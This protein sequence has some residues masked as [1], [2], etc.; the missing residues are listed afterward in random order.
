MQVKPRAVGSVDI[1]QFLSAGGGLGSS[2][3]DQEYADDLDRGL[4][5]LFGANA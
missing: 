4:H 3:A 5:R 1:P 2:L